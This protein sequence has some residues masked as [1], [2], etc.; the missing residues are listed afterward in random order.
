MQRAGPRAGAV[1]TERGR[2]SYKHLIGTRRLAAAGEGGQADQRFLGGAADWMMTAD[3]YI[4][5][6][7]S[8]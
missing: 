1:R 3:R 7:R 6:Y 4:R 8:V 2:S 5:E